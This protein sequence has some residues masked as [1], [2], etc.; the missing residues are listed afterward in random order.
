[1]I[2]W[3]QAYNHQRPHTALGGLPPIRRLN[4]LL[5]NDS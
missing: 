2:P 3:L 1:M 5:G 4:N